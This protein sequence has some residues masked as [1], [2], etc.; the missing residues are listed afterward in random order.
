MSG[1]NTKPVYDD[2]IHLEY[3]FLLKRPRMDRKARAAQFSAF[4]ALSGHGAAISETA[5]IT[6]RRIELDEDVKAD[7]DAKLRVIGANLSAQPLITVTYFLPDGKKDGGAYLTVS[8]SVR[9]IDVYA[10]VIIL[11]D[12]TRIPI[13]DILKIESAL[14]AALD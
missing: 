11:A 12:G 5:R 10:R 1:E 7:L 4:A 6:G 14:F 2:I 13:G 8:D 3:P 9:K